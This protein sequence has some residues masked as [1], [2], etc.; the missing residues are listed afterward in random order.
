MTHNAPRDGLRPPTRRVRL[1][2]AVALSVVAMAV[3]WGHTEWG[4]AYVRGTAADLG[5]P[6]E[7]ARRILQ[8]LGDRLASVEAPDDGVLFD[9]DQPSDLNA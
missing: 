1:A 8:S 9:V 7:G 3:F 4:P 5:G 2:A 6:L